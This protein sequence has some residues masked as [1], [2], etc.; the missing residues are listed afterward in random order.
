LIL[1]SKANHKKLVTLCVAYPRCRRVL[2]K[3]YHMNK[4]YIPAY[5]SCPMLLLRACHWLHIASW[6]KR[7]LFRSWRYYLPCVIGAILLSAT[8]A[9]A[10]TVTVT[11]GN[12]SGPGSL[13][14]AIV[15]AS[16][17]DT[18]N[19]GPSVTA[20]NL[21]SGELVID[22]NLTISG[23]GANRLAVQRSTTAPP[24]LEF[25]TLQQAPSPSLSRASRS[26]MALPDSLGEVFRALAY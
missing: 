4:N 23:P 6:V 9:L 11:N 21:T 16:P 19:C 13:R 2:P 20:V 26:Q 17:G 25:S 1:P 5:V 3:E 10:G 8:D 15:F 22:K 12:D 14:R 24:S 18:I 7:R